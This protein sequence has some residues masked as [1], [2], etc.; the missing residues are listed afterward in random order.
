MTDTPHTERRD[1]LTV[2][3]AAER[4]GVPAPTINGRIN[5][6]LIAAVKVKGRLRIPLA[7]IEDIEAE[8]ARTLTLRQ[9]ADALGIHFSTAQLWIRRGKLPVE[10]H[11][12]KPRVPRAAVEALVEQRTTDAVTLTEAAEELGVSYG[13]T[14]Y[15]RRTQQLEV[16]EVD[17][18][19]RITRQSL[20]ALKAR[21]A[22]A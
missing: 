17:G 9:T 7:A 8:N 11:T 22:T 18:S 3:E 10:T 14:N 13:L 12:G 1:W 2:D 4:L 16:V 20:D 21:R 15:Y 6:G 5:R 19:P